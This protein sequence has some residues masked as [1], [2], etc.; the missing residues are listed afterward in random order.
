LVNQFVLGKVNM[1]FLIP[2]FCSKVALLEGLEVD[3]Y[4]WGI[5]T[6]SRW[7]L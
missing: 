2:S 7:L 1:E 5:L 6:T 3:Q 4:M